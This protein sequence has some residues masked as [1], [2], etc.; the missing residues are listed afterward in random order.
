[1]WALGDVLIV[2]RIGVVGESCEFNVFCRAAISESEEM[3]CAA[4]FSQELFVSMS[5]LTLVE[6]LPILETRIGTYYVITGVQ[7][8]YYRMFII[9]GILFSNA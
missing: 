3:L 9:Y 7:K 4:T 8:E 1:M 6:K 5:E 2:L